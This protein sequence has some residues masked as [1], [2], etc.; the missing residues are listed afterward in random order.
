MFPRVRQTAVT[1]VPAFFDKGLPVFT[2]I[3]GLLQSFILPVTVNSLVSLSDFAGGGIDPGVPAGLLRFLPGVLT[4][5]SCFGRAGHIRDKSFSFI[6]PNFRS[7]MA[8]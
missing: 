6:S 5:E 3:N 8:P 2:Q 1:A 7:L 4:E